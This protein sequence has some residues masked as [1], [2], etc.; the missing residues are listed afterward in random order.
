MPKI[1]IRVSGTISQEYEI[2]DNFFPDVPNLTEE[3][4]LELQRE[5]LKDDISSLWEDG[6]ISDV[7]VEKC[8][9]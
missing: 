4:M 3:K 8:I 7:K 9:T 2:D 5:C 1:K 6:T